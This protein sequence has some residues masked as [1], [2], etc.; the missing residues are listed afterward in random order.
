M[1]LL[2]TSGRLLPSRPGLGN[3]AAALGTGCILRSIFWLRYESGSF[4]APSQAGLRRTRRMFHT[5]DDLD[6]GHVLKKFRGEFACSVWLD[7]RDL[8]N[9]HPG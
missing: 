3:L 2:E 6:T 7:S 9:S 1:V 5:D 8:L 4:L